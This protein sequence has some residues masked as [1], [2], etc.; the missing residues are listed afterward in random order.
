MCIVCG[1]PAFREESSCTGYTKMVGTFAATFRHP[2][3][4]FCF[5]LVHTSK[6]DQVHKNGL[7]VDTTHNIFL[8]WFKKYLLELQSIL[9]HSIVEDVAKH[10]GHNTT[11]KTCMQMRLPLPMI[12]QRACEIFSRSNYFHHHQLLRQDLNQNRYSSSSLQL[13]LQLLPQG[14]TRYRRG[15]LPR[16]VL[17]LAVLPLFSVSVVIVMKMTKEK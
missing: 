5:F 6:M 2:G 8:V 16:K 9:S 1:H 13:Q 4:F 12:L 15:R 7:V 11:T 10:H 14:P 3:S 17:V